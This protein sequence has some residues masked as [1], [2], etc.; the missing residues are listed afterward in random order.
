M[1]LNILLWIGGMLFSLGIFALKV[2][3]GLG[4]GKVRL[5]GVVAALTGYL[6]LFMVIALL[7]EPLVRRLE[8]LLR[9][10]PY[11][12]I[13]LAAGL[14]AWGSYLVGSRG[15]GHTR[16]V[17]TGTRLLLIIPC[18]V[19]LTAMTFSTWAALHAFTVHPLLVGLGL[20][21]AFALMAGIVL[22]AARLRPGNRSEVSLG[23]AMVVIGL[24]FAGSMFLP[25][26]INEAREM[27]ASF[28]SR[29]AGAGNTSGTW[30]LTCLPLLLLI[31]FFARK[32]RRE[33]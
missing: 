28:I 33:L 17:R 8:P 14:I 16:T 7:A 3:L 18:P 10:G 23:L 26:K 1:D 11:L 20:G 15:D 4:Y 12:H 6:A 29:N 2:G 9:K 24:Y 22:S 13:I 31:G 32:S 5:K 30:L 27:Y 21:S 25:G 19:C